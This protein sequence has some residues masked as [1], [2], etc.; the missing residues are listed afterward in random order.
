M[1]MSKPPTGKGSKTFFYWQS[2]LSN[3]KSKEIPINHA[4]IIHAWIF[5]LNL[6]L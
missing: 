5:K 1:R 4:G 6:I 2:A 3:S